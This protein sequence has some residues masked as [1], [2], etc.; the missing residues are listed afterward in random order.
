V[1]SEGVYVDRT[2]QGLKPRFVKVEP[3]GDADIARNQQAKSL[4]LRAATSLARLWQQ[5]AKRQ[6]AG[7]A[8]SM[9]WRS[10]RA[11]GEGWPPAGDAG[12]PQGRFRGVRSRGASDKMAFV[13]PIRQSSRWRFCC[14]I[15]SL[16][17][18]P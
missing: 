6:P 17:I 7:A 16:C 13:S 3:P 14:T 8:R 18:D 10:H 1:T 15:S 4:E 12:M 5:Q 11:G 2:D 9:A